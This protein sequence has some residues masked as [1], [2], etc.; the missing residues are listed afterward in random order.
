[1]CERIGEDTHTE[2][3]RKWG[4]ARDTEKEVNPSPVEPLLIWP[5]WFSWPGLE[6]VWLNLPRSPT[7]VKAIT[8]QKNRVTGEGEGTP[9][10]SSLPQSPPLHPTRPDSRRTLFAPQ[11]P[12]FVFFYI[13]VN[14]G[15][16]SL[17]WVG[18]QGPVYQGQG[19]GWNWEELRTADSSHT[20]THTHTLTHTHCCSLKV[21]PGYSSRPLSHSFCNLPL[22]FYFH[23]SFST[24]ALL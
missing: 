13:A 11:T 6:M 17:K 24:C 16:P 23:T 12:L 3:E 15:W 21:I 9:C 18:H 5:I 19:G 2:K 4:T 1:M 22:L 14:D 10:F 20:H 8:L 7:G